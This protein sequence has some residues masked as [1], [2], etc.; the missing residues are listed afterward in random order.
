MRPKLR[1]TADKCKNMGGNWLT[2]LGGA[3]KLP[4]F[5]GGSV[6]WSDL[7]HRSTAL[8]LQSSG[9]ARLQL[10]CVAVRCCGKRGLPQ[11]P[12]ALSCRQQ[13]PVCLGRRQP[14]GMGVGYGV[15][16]EASK[17]AHNGIQ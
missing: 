17:C 4:G 10:L 14:A 12:V 2:T 8:K 5:I 3:A 13:E 11:E 7:V 16:W 6:A 1:T 9:Y 15:V